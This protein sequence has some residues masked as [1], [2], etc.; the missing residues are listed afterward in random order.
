ML[1]FITFALVGIVRCRALYVVAFSWVL[2]VYRVPYVGLDADP[3]VI[4]A[5]FLPVCL[6]AC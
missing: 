6:L 3:A 4:L 5:N 1:R 2:T